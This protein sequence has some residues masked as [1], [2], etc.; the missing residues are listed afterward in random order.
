MKVQYRDIEAQVRKLDPKYVAVLV[1]GPDEGLVRE[2]GEK[3][4]RQVAEDLRDPFLVANLDPDT[5]KSEPALLGDEAA[6]ISM[7]GGRRVVRVD[8]A[9]ENAKEAAKSFLENALA[10]NR[11][12]GLVVIT[13]GNLKPTS[14]LRK[15]FEGAKNAAAIP[16]YEDNQA[17]LE[18]LVTSV[19][20]DNGLR[21][22][23]DAVA[24]LQANMGSD[25]MISRNELEK[26]VT[27]MGKA[28]TGETLTVTLKDARA[29]VGDSGALTLDMIAKA[30]SGG[31]LR[32]LDDVLFKSFNRGENPISILY[33]VSR[34]LQR[35]HF[36]RGMMDQGQ[37]IE[38]AMGKLVPRVFPMEAAQFKAHL[39]KWTTEGLSRA[40][41][42]VM[43]A[44]QDCKTTDMPAETICARA[45]LRIANAARARR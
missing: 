6:A 45:C 29:C 3:I 4:A 21:I 19:M 33:A 1:Y 13:A 28:P 9:G 11:E 16:C 26:L 2:R 27:Y 39:S 20:R 14:G 43:L 42:I 10:V 31:D 41:E 5:L 23:P 36:V 8:G 22:E 24:Y 15:L 30:T 37:A 7:M 32:N 34:R 18:G 12:D 38:Q 17:A 40:L 44:E 25:R 35:M